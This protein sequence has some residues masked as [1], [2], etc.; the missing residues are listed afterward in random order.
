MAEF[1]GF[2]VFI[3]LCALYMFPMLIAWLRG[4]HQVVAISVLNFFLGWTLL[5]WVGALVWACTAITRPVVIP[6]PTSL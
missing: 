4:H 3:L 2:L 6:Q 1:Q 5:G